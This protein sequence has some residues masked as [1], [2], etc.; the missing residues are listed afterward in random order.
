MN[1][2]KIVAIIEKGTDGRF[3]ITSSQSF[4]K[5]HFGGFGETIEEAKADFRESVE[6]CRDLALANGEGVPEEYQ[7]TFRYDMPSFFE[8]FDFI[9]ASRFAQYAGINESKMRQYKSGAAFPGEKT[10]KKIVAAI[11]RIGAELSSVSI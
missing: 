6:D 11:H 1:M 3:A 10:T 5:N 9:N 7:V 8:D 4:G 2:Y